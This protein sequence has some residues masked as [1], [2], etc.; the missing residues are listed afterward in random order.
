MGEEDEMEAPN[1]ILNDEEGNHMIDI[2]NIV[3]REDKDGGFDLEPF[4]DL[5]RKMI[6]TYL[7]LKEEEKDGDDDCSF[8]VSLEKQLVEKLVTKFGLNYLILNLYPNN[9]GYT[10]GMKNLPNKSDNIYKN[11]SNG[12]IHKSG[13]KAASDL[14]NND[15]KTNE[16]CTHLDDHFDSK[17]SKDGAQNGD[18]KESDF[19]ETIKLPYEEED[20]LDFIDNGELPPMLVDIFDDFNENND[21]QLFYCGSIFMEI[22]DYRKNTSNQTSNYES[23]FVRLRPTNQTLLNDIARLTSSFSHL[24]NWTQEEKTALEAK[25]ILETAEPLCLDPNPVVAIISNKLDYEKKWFKASKSVERLMKKNS[26]VYR[27]RIKKFESLPAPKGLELF[28]FLQSRTDRASI[29]SRLNKKINSINGNKDCKIDPID[30][31][32]IEIEKFAKKL[33]P[34]NLR[35]DNTLV[36]SDEYIMEF[37]NSEGRS[38]VTCVAIYHRSIDD[39]YFG[40]LFLDKR[41]DNSNRSGNSCLFR[42]GHKAMVNKYIDQF[43]EIL[44][45]N[46]RKP[47]KITHKS[48]NHP[49]KVTYTNSANQF[50]GPNPSDNEDLDGRDNLSKKPKIIQS[51]PKNAVSV[52]RNQHRKLSS[53]LL[54]SNLSPST[55]TSTNVPT[56]SSSTLSAASNSSSSIPINEFIPSNSSTIQ[57]NSNCTANHRNS[58]QDESK[59][60]QETLV[61]TPSLPIGTYTITGTNST[62]NANLPQGINLAS[63]NLAQCSNLRLHNLVSFPNIQGVPQQ[64]ITVPISLTMMQGSGSSQGQTAMAVAN[65]NIV[66]NNNTVNN[67]VVNNNIVNL[68]QHQISHQIQQQIQ[69][70][71]SHPHPH[72]YQQSHLHPHT[73]IQSQQ[74]QQQQLHPH[75]RTYLIDYDGRKQV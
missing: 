42:L 9:E 51:N 10:I 18:C 57:I 19:I 24:K 40:K 66:N 62:T 75:H 7:E 8:G 65:T 72:A 20:L 38:S 23:S 27:N 28:D 45:E 71:H 2:N 47:V 31:K 36:K 1:I 69:H 48:S 37:M 43:K 49:T 39:S 25:I 61:V 68:Q 4:N 74:H 13:D 11:N 16:N 32:L 73:H 12:I 29:S 6:Q 63:L 14:F 64:Q 44:T 56:S 41:K 3:D 15:S 5:K 17:D 52:L 22:R 46:G 30:P 35:C 70:S 26:Q 53:S 59:P 60:Q 50:N 67:N 21:H 55:T 58:E 54:S 33:E 34:V